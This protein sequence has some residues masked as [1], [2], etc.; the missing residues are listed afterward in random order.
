[1]GPAKL[2]CVSRYR[3]HKRCVCEKEKLP[4]RKEE[5]EGRDGGK[6]RKD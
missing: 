4:V 5:D 1:M 6:E 3:E 2:G